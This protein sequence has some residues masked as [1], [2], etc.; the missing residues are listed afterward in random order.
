MAGEPM[1]AIYLSARLRG[2]SNG[3]ESAGEVISIANQAAVEIDRLRAMLHRIIDAPA[4]TPEAVARIQAWL[5]AE[6]AAG[7][8][9]FDPSDAWIARLL[10]AADGR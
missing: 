3:W 5:A 10:E 4:P 2:L 7:R 9:V 6:R 1:E 8:C